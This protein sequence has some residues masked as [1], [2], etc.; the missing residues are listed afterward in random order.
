MSAIKVVAYNSCGFFLCVFVC[1][2][3]MWMDGWMDI[4]VDDCMPIHWQCSV[5]DKKKQ[6][7]KISVIYE[8]KTYESFFL[9]LDFGL[10]NR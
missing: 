6:K 8:L 9:S 10:I 3:Y 4:C 5:C 2:L 1:V 7:K